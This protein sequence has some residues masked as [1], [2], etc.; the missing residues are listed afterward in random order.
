MADTKISALGDVGALAGGDKFAVADASDLTVSKSTT[1]DAIVTYA[2][3]TLAPKANPSFTGTPVFASGIPATEI[4]NGITTTNTAE[5]S[6]TVVSTTV[7]YITDSA[8]TMPASAKAG[9]QVGTLMIWDVYMTKTAGTGTGIFRIGIYRG[10]NGSTA[11]T[12]DVLQTIGT[13]TAVV[14][15]LHLRVTLRVNTTGATGGYFWTMI[16]EPRLAGA[17]GFGIA[18]GTTG[19]FSGTIASVAMNTAS[20]KF[21]LAF[22]STTATPTIRIVSVI[23]QVHHMD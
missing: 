14:D 18:V 6:Q 11:D 16:P 3:V 10:T 4:P 21:G 22:T 13:T 1:A 17:T 19:L 12:Q 5:Q 8:L 2:G 15:A 23:G 20:L 9:M 7:Y